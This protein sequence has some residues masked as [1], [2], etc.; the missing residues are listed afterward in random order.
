MT[1]ESP[2]T[3]A[4]ISAEYDGICFP[5]SSS[6]H[7]LHDCT[8]QTQPPAS[9]QS[10]QCGDDD[11][12][13]T[14]S[15]GRLRLN[16]HM[17]ASDETYTFDSKV[18]MKENTPGTLN[19]AAQTSKLCCRDAL[20]QVHNTAQMDL[21]DRLGCDDGLAAGINGLLSSQSWQPQ[22]SALYMRQKLHDPLNSERD[23]C[24]AGATSLGTSH[25]PRLRQSHQ[26]NLYK[27]RTSSGVQDIQAPE[28]PKAQI[29]RD[30][31]SGMRCRDIQRFSR[32]DEVT[33]S[34]RQK[35]VTHCK[36]KNKLYIS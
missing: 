19:G 4:E 29:A 6:N 31:H 25:T 32:C 28:H 21:W 7:M 14:A 24:V 16:C 15:Q 10:S 2:N 17:L 1:N 30:A 8:G 33:G 5:E 9:H 3:D 22:T 35:R 18:D 13:V 12:L 23:S 20:R 11:R 26:T 27:V 36:R 34:A